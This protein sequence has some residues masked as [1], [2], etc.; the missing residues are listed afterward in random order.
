MYT[1]A[2][3]LK[4]QRDLGESCSG[5]NSTHKCN[6]Y[7]EYICINSKCRNVSEKETAQ[8][9]DDFFTAGRITIGS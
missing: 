2:F 7:F 8:S 4:Y 3:V 1:A 9:Y 5:M 6:S